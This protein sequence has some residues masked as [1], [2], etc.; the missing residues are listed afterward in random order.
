MSAAEQLLEAIRRGDA[1]EVA[2]LVERHPAVVGERQ[3]GISALLLAVYSGHPEIARILLD[4]GATLDVFEASAVGDVDRLRELLAEDRSQASAFA[5]DGFTPLGLAAFF[6][7]PEAVRLLL[8]NGADVNVA[9]RNTQRVAPLHS[10]VAGGSAEIVRD[11]LAHGADIHARQDL[12]F[13]PL[14]GAAADGNE[15]MIRML[16]ARGSDRAA[17]T[18]AGKTAADIARER[19]KEKVARLL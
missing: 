10:A 16:L 17:R 2:K 11:L 1:N 13:T 19:G 12:G 9:S 8:A 7:H 5:P 18:D 15:E 14:H 4:H 6:R 3:S